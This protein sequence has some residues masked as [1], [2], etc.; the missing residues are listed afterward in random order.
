MCEGAKGVHI[1]SLLEC[2]EVLHLFTQNVT[3]IIGS[4]L[5]H[6]WPQLHEVDRWLHELFGADL[7][8]LTKKSVAGDGFRCSFTTQQPL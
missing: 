6:N 3:E 2:N 5:M 4:E 7:P 1:Q 8:I